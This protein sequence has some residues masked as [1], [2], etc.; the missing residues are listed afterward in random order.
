MISERPFNL[1]LAKIRKSFVS[2]I[3]QFLVFSALIM[4]LLSCNNRQDNGSK[5]TQIN[6]PDQGKTDLPFCYEGI[7]EL[8]RGDFIVKPNLNILPGSTVIPNGYYFGHAGII[9]EGASDE[10]PDS[11]LAKVK[12]IESTARD[13]PYG[14]QVRE[15]AGYK[16][17]KNAFIHN[18]S[19][20]PAFQ[21]QRYRLRMDLTESQIDSIIAFIV[22][23]KGD[24]STWSA[25]KSY[26]DNTLSESLVISGHKKNWADNSYWYC[27]L[28]IWQSVFYVTGVDLDANGGYEVYPNDL[29]NSP[30]FD[31]S[32]DGEQRRVR[33]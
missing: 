30:F 19:F 25:Q 33:F 32:A 31:N 26:P 29:I 3:F 6:S 8:K 7:S 23:Q 18:D 28:L 16:V 12:L 24:T 14:Y 2:D 10:N 11:L 17:S 20:G 9:I 21:G 13:L 4:P 27:S 5:V 1:I 22:Q 15:T